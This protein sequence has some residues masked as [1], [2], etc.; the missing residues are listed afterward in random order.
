MLLG[1]GVDVLDDTSQ[2]Y[3]GTLHIVHLLSQ[4]A[5]TITGSKGWRNVVVVVKIYL[6]TS[7]SWH[8][9]MTTLPCTFLLCKEDCFVDCSCTVGV[10][11]S[12]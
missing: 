2:M 12:N 6:S 5:G 7:G 10:T 8:N 11:Y 4:G 3:I 1:I 9:N